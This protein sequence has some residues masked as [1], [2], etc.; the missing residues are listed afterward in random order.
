[1]SRLALTFSL[2]WLLSGCSADED[3]ASDSADVGVSTSDIGTGSDSDATTAPDDTV[4]VPDTTPEPDVDTPPTGPAGPCALNARIGGIT[5]E[6]GEQFSFVTAEIANGVNPA[7]VLE[8]VVVEGDCKLLK[9]NNLFCNPPCAPGQTCG[10]DETCIEFPVPQDVG[11][12]TVSGL[13]TTVVMESV[14]GTGTYFATDVA[15]PIVTGGEAI[16]AT[17]SAGGYV[18]QITLQGA[19]GHA[20]DLITSQWSVVPGAPLT[21][22][23]AAPPADG[24]TMIGLRLNID[25]HGN[26]PVVVACTFED[27]GEASIPATLIDQLINSGVSGF[28]NGLLRR[29]TVDSVSTDQGCVDLLVSV[30]REPEDV[31][32]AG[33]T[34][35][36]TPA[37]CPDGTT[38]NLAIETC[39]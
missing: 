25:Q 5:V 35:C 20:L 22:Q 8:E 13:S 16:T 18:G 3:A 11:T 26:S 19:G 21:I 38:C 17:T 6:A 14:A 28:P 4:S 36:K 2:I 10:L 23:W 12:V 31:S 7:T 30:P 39:Q 15:H 32:I 24:R 1:M 37:D 27:D 29:Q 34:P 9:R 33:H